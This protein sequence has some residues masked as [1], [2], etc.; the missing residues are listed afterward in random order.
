[1]TLWHEHDDVTLY[2]EHWGP[3]YPL[4]HNLGSK[5]H[6]SCY[7]VANSCSTL[8]NPMDCSPPGSS[9]H[10]ISQARILEWVAISF[11]RGLPDPRIEPV[12]PAL[13]GRFFTIEQSVY[14]EVLMWC[15]LAHYHELLS[16]LLATG[17]HQYTLVISVY[18]LLCERR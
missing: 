1:M 6:I 14:L 15:A 4:S 8:C 9:V 10:G 12:S 3:L 7:L 16:G 11:S 13:A 5:F 2:F 18:S 17:G